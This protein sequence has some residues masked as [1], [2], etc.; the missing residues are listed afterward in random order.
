MNGHMA[1][2]EKVAARVAAGKE[3]LLELID[4][5][6]DKGVQING[7][8]LPLNLDCGV[9]SLAL[10]RAATDW[11][12]LGVCLDTCHAWIDG[13]EPLKLVRELAPRVRTTH[14]SDTLGAHDSH[15][16]PGDGAVDFAAVAGEL[17][18]AGFDGVV[19][20]ECSLWMLRNR[21]RRNDEHPGDTVPPST[22][23]YLE[24]AAEAA[25]KI[26][27]DIEEARQ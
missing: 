20:L 22:E 6:G 19:D 18:Q 11:P 4:Y 1:E 8:N 2:G 16:I 3:S 14:F 9:V 15:L 17:G 12:E 13:H 21:R 10:L 5:A 23:H 7:E 27:A 24:R 25:R 26:A